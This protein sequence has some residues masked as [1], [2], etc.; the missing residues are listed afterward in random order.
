[1]FDR[2]SHLVVALAF[3]SGLL[4][5]QAAVAQEKTA[6]SMDGSWHFKV[7]PYVWG[8]GMKGTVGVGNAVSVPVDASFGDILENLDFG[9]FG[10]F[11]ARKDRVGF[12]VDLTHMNLG[13]DV[14]G[15]GP[16][17]LGVDADLRSLSLEGTFSYR[18]ANDAAKG[19]YVDLVAGARYMRN[20]AGLTL[21]RNGEAVAG[22]EQTLDWVD[23]LAGVRFYL[24]LSGK[25]ALHG[26]ADV[27]GF[28][29]DFTWNALGGLD[30]A[31]GQRWALGAGYRYMDV[32]YDKGEAIERRV[33]QI[34]YK[35]P[36][37]FGAYSW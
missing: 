34:V 15:S 29:S 26:R 22:T 5:P 30:V 27:A 31:L 9:I 23:A 7:V 11:A 20:R 2:T 32:D 28:G 16:V 14:T 12:G 4:V 19:R 35:G 13:A 8:S 21:E 37:L 10:Q 3:A 24:P 33:W 25:L 36:Y 17:G 18:V 1:M 6:T